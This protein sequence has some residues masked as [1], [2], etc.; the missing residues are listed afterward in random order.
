VIAPLRLVCCASG[1]GRTILNLLDHIEANRLHAS[2]ECVVLSSA[3]RPAAS[4]CRDRGLLV[5][6][7]PKGVEIDDW[8]VARIAETAPDLVCLCGYLRLLPIEPWM[9]QRVINIHPAL[10]PAYGGRGMHGLLVHEA[11]IAAG[12]AKS[13]CT[14]HFVDE[15]Y[16]HGPTILQRT[17]DVRPDDSPSTLAARVFAEECVAMPEAIGLIASGHAGVTR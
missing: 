12:E 2:I 6:E 15:E 9:R 5:L 3:G 16:D 17:C 13:G 11:V 14:V 7:P 8:V 4:R 10:L 1:G